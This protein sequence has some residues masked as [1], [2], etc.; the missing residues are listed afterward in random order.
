MSCGVRVWSIPGSRFDSLE[1]RLAVVPVGSLERHGDHLPLGTDTL[2]ALYIAERVSEEL[3]AHLF[4]PVWYGSSRGLARFPGTVDV[5]DDAFHEYVYRV[6]RGVAS[7]GYRMVLAVNGHGGNSLALRL[8]AKRASYETGVP[9]AVVD[10][11]SELAQE[12][13]R[14]LFQYPGHAG[15]DETSAMLYIAPESVDMSKAS[16]HVVETVPR[17]SVYSPRLEEMLYPRAVLGKATAASA[18]KGREWLEEVVKD[19]VKRIREAA[20]MLGVKI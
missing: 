19:L 7:M 16:D 2:E 8:A 18:E 6:L 14:Q 9:I 15:E 17:L 5:G 13:R 10:W 20:E 11:W 1:K 12:K 3:C 4:P